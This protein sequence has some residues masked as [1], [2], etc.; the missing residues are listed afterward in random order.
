[1]RFG[2]LLFIFFSTIFSAQKIDLRKLEDK[3]FLQ[4]NNSEYKK[5]QDTLLSLI[6]TA[7]YKDKV[8][9]YLLLSDTYKRL[10]D[11]EAV[12]KFVKEAQK[13][14]QENAYSDVLNTL[15]AHLAYAYFDTQ[16][17]K[18]A[19]AVMQNIRKSKNKPLSD[20]DNAKITMQEGYLLYL[21]KKYRES[22]VKYFASAKLMEKAS[23]CDLP[24]VYG[25]QMQL[26]YDLYN[27][28]E[29]ALQLYSKSLAKA[30]SCNILKYK[31]YA[32]EV[33][34]NLYTE[35]NNPSK[36]LIFKKKYDSL[37][38][39]YRMSENLSKLHDEKDQILTAEKHVVSQ[40][41]TRIIVFS[42]FV[43]LLLGGLA[44]L[45]GRKTGIYKKKSSAYEKELEEMKQ[46]LIK[47]SESHSLKEP[48]KGEVI[49]TEKQQKIVQWICDGK[50]N[51]EIADLSFVS[52]STIKY[53]IKNIYDLLQVNGRTE[54]R[55]KI[56]KNG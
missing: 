4:N 40:S 27:N 34:M 13:V 37:D 36:L 16:N 50:T 26:Y 30:D 56:S 5:S 35:K 21:E 17:Y 9:L 6:A 24:I 7:G 39:L 28:D 51:K 32:T 38:D 45:Y 23:P 18:R 41:K 25:K 22:E 46:E 52:E 3:I 11:Y 8:E 53:H 1:M 29:K 44:F 2:F 12:E 55:E 48:A 43:V 54:L 10:Q 42:A 33:M 15:D 31:L 49:L 47:Y 19:S 14:A 20:D